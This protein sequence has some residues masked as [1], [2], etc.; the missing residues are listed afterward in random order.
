MPPPALLEKRRIL[1]LETLYDL[2]LAL[3]AQR[4]EGELVE[5]LLQRVCAVMDPQAAVAATRDGE[6][7]LRSVAS[8]G[9]REGEVAEAL[10]DDPLWAEVRRQEG[11][12]VRRAGSFS[13]R[14]FRQLLAT[15]LAYRG[16]TLGLLAV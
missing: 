2:A 8:V 3:Q 15:P 13:G 4:P 10:A 7:R 12:L 9:W 1:Q 14:E 6:G 5:E 11:A 16:E